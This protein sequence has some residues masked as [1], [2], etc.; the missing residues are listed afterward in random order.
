MCWGKKTS[1]RPSIDAV[2]TCLNR[3]ATTWV[4][5]V[6]A[7]MLASKAGVSQVM[8]LKGDQAKDFANRL[9]EARSREF[10]HTLRSES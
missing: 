8:N 10:D 3:A 6:P 4:V 7:F 5:D 2:S 9:D 1:V